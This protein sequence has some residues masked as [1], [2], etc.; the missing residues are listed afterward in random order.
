M[1]TRYTKPNEYFVITNV[2]GD[3]QI[4]Y[5]A[6]NEVFMTQSLIFET[7]KSFLYYFLN[8]KIADL[9]LK[10]LGFTLSKTHFEDKMLVSTWKPSVKLNSK[11]G[12]IELVHENQLPI[13]I[14]YYDEKYKLTK[15]IYY[16]DYYNHPSLKLPQKVVEFNYLPKGDSVVNKLVYSNIKLNEQANSTWFNYKI[17]ANAKV[18]K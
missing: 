6:K 8:N 13:Y 11:I 5:P 12:K 1:I 4:Y 14:A 16:Y 7:E 10:D 18:V 15:K 2:S 9:G 3:A 17:P